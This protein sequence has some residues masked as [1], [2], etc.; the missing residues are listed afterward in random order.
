MSDITAKKELRIVLDI[1]ATKAFEAMVVALKA[2]TPTIKISP[3]QLVSFLVAD[4]FEAHFEKDKAVLIAEFFDSDAYFDTARKKAK[5]S[6]DYEE[7]MAAAL[8]DA[9]KI[10]S[11]RRNKMRG[12]NKPH[13]KSKE[14]VTP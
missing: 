5:G 14:A 13:T 2:E 12:A 7:K 9:L 8:S 11:K 6:A 4:F 1:V 10:R 3:S